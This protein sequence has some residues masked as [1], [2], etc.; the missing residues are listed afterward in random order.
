MSQYMPSSAICSEIAEIAD[1]S[2]AQ[3]GRPE[4]F[5]LNAAT[6]ART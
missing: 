3:P 5:S 6:R 1:G 2:A 4:T